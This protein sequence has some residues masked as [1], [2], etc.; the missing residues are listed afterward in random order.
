MSALTG[1]S[2]LMQTQKEKVVVFFMVFGIKNVR[3]F[4]M[5]HQPQ[6]SD[7]VRLKVLNSGL[8]APKNNFEILVI[9][10]KILNTIKHQPQN[11]TIR[12]G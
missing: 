4:I 3:F 6:K 1:A 9:K 11:R 7:T 5:K 12:Q 10:I 2:L 8:M